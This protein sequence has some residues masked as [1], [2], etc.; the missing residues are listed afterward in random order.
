[1]DWRPHIGAYIVESPHPWLREGRKENRSR[2]C[3]NTVRNLETL[4]GFFSDLPLGWAI[5]TD[6]EARDAVMREFKAL[7]KNPSEEDIEEATAHYQKLMFED[8][9]RG[10]ESICLAATAYV[11]DF[12]PFLQENMTEEQSGSLSYMDRSTL[13]VQWA[14]EGVDGRKVPLP[15]DTYFRP[16]TDAFHTVWGPCYW[17]DRETGKMHEIKNS[18]LGMFFNKRRHSAYGTVYS[19]LEVRYCETLP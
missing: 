12:N 6:D 17:P 1:M 10:R 13:L 9:E 16:E 4:M 7:R 8:F 15:L 19:Y 11:P 5:P 3:H 2:T 14:G 18:T